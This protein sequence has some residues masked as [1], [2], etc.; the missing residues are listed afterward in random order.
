MNKKWWKEAVVYQIYPRSFMNSN[1]DGIGDLQGII[2]KLDYLKELGID[3]IWLS[4]IYKSPDH[5]NGYDISDY[6]DIMPELG[7]IEDFDELLAG[8][9]Q[10]GMKVIMDLVVN[11]TS[12]EHSW[13]VESRSSE[14]NPKRDFYIW[15]KGSNGKEPN[16]WAADFGG[17]AW[18]KDEKTVEYYL[19]LFSKHQPDLNWENP[20]LR[21]AIYA[22]MR[23]WLDKGIDGFRMDVINFLAKAPEFPDAPVIDPDRPGD[24]VHGGALYANQP[25]IHDHLQEMNREVLSHYDIMTI[26]ECHFMSPQEGRLYADESRHELDMVFQYDIIHSGGDL[27][28]LKK[29]VH[30]WHQEFKGKAWNTINLN[31]HDTARQVSHFGDDKAYRIE[32]AKLLATFVLTAPGTPYLYQGEEIGMTNANFPHIEHYRDIKMLNGHE[33]L[34]ESGKRPEEALSELQL[35]SRDN[36]RTPMQWDNSQHAGF[37]QGTPW[38]GVNPNFKSINVADAE[39]DRNS[40]LHFYQRMIKFRK[41]NEALIYGDYIPLNNDESPIY[42]YKR[43]SN[44]VVFLI[45]LNFSSEARVFVLPLEMREKTLELLLSNYRTLSGE[46]K[47]ELA[48]NAWEARIYDVR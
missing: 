31:N 24:Y 28:T 27:E 48:L 14:N 29:R 41:K 8:A 1:G 20:E 11:H 2:S 23:W 7:T 6:Y 5:D 26:G 38:I 21:K 40:V 12:D 39:K 15:H 37:T 33:E 44:N 36:G 9:H 25:G 3:V 4:P 45:V 47:G 35:H 18:N 17:S 19:H 43:A 10:R 34:L 32:S 13:F 42:A 16:N 30:A 46:D 22:M